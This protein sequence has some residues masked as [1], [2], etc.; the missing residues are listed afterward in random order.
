MTRCHSVLPLTPAGISLKLCSVTFT[1]CHCLVSVEGLYFHK[2]VLKRSC[3]DLFAFNLLDPQPV[4]SSTAVHHVGLL[5][6]CVSTLVISGNSSW[7][8]YKNHTTLIQHNAYVNGTTRNRP[9]GQQTLC[10]CTWR[11]FHYR[12]ITQCTVT[13]S[14][15]C[16]HND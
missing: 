5:L 15:A 14:D 13:D 10:T 7:L 1:Y 6:L 8:S 3:S 2:L 16:L 4:W 11:R 12:P 9:Q